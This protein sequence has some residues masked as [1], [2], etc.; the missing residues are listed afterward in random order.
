MKGYILRDSNYDDLER[1]K[2][3]T[4]ESG[5]AWGVWGVRRGARQQPCSQGTTCPGPMECATVRAACKANAGRGGDDVSGGV[6]DHDNAPLGGAGGNG[7]AAP[8]RTGK[9]CA[10][11]SVLL[12]T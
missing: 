3:A 12:W 10:L 2:L 7:E 8:V 1:A 9:L 5:R 6:P 4:A 11:C